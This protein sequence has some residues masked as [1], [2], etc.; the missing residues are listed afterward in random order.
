[1]LSPGRRSL[2]LTTLCSLSM[3]VAVACSEPPDDNGELSN[4]GENGDSDGF[5]TCQMEGD[6]DC[7][8]FV[9]GADTSID[10]IDHQTVVLDG[11]QVLMIGGRERAESGSASGTDTWEVFD[12]ADDSVEVPATEFAPTR[13]DPSVVR[14]DNGS[15][16]VL[17]GLDHR[18]DAKSSVK[19][20]SPD[21]HEWTELPAMNAAYRQ[22]I[23][24]DD[25]RVLALAVAHSR[26]PNDI[27]G[28]VFDVTTLEWS[29]VSSGELFHHRI[30]DFWFIQQGDGDILFV[31]SHR[32]PQEDQIPEDEIPD[33]FEDVDLTIYETTA[34]RYSPDSG[35]VEQLK[36]FDHQ[37]FDF[38][39]ELVWLEESQ[40]ALVQI[41]TFE[42]D[43]ETLLPVG[44]ETFGYLFDPAGDEFQPHYERDESPGQILQVLP[45]DQVVF[46]GGPPLQIHHVGDDAWF[47]FVQMPSGIYYSTMDLLE[48]C[49]LFVS[50]EWAFPDEELRGVHTGY[51]EPVR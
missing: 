47:D 39:V 20:F 22:A 4:I 23:G 13:R 15:A 18:G 35:D 45:G 12:V 34:V 40:Q 9:D 30:D 43:D 33:E 19:H 44:D 28:Q 37:S 50:G 11:D 16:L 49:R 42:L 51:C 6:W 41:E 24:L 17:G 3:L 31:Y 8:Q 10:R 46:D 25:G 5:A 21:T 48:D 32:A 26:N 1:M 38:D 27:V 2:S 36:L 7:E 14:L 29:S